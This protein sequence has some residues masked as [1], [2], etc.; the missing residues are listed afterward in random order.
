MCAGGWDRCGSTDRA[1]SVIAQPAF[2]Y[3]SVLS[4]SHSNSSKQRNNPHSQCACTC[5]HT[6]AHTPQTSSTKHGVYFWRTVLFFQACFCHYHSW[7]SSCLK[8]AGCRTASRSLCRVGCA[9][10]ADRES[11]CCDW[12]RVHRQPSWRRRGN[13]C[14]AYDLDIGI[15]LI[16]T[17]CCHITGHFGLFQ[18]PG[19]FEN[20]GSNEGKQ[21]ND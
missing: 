8:L 18:A 11:R 20:C 4:Q 3:H 15:C 1:I 7:T 14:R 5:T 13:I 2:Y 17:S 16:F 21:Q 19:M 12:G 9:A 6:H 10:G